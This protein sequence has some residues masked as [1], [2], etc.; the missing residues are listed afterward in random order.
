MLEH[1]V[2]Y[3]NYASPFTVTNNIIAGNLSI[4]I[5]LENNPA[6]RVIGGSGKFLHNTIAGNTVDYGILVDTGGVA[7]LTNTIIVSHTLG[8]SVTA[9]S[10]ARLGATLWGSGDWANGKD[11]GGAGT[12]LTGTVNIWGNPVF[13]DPAEYNYHIGSSSAAID[14]GVNAGVTNDIDGEPRPVGAGFDIGA[15]ELDY[16]VYLPVVRKN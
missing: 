11:W 5:S 3:L 2:F 10:T 9:G 6:V 4:N 1:R 8:I 7:V 15:D 14:A 16:P 12:I 13:V